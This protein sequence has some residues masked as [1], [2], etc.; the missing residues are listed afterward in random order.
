MQTLE[1]LIFFSK[2]GCVKLKTLQ[3]SKILNTNTNK[4]FQISFEVTYVSLRYT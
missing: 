3:I 4:I 2:D 1:S